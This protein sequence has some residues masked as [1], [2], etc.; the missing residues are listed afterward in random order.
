MC[1]LCISVKLWIVNYT[2][3]TIFRNKYMYTHPFNNAKCNR[4]N[5]P[6]HRIN[7][8]LLQ[9]V[10]LSMISLN[11]WHRSCRR[12]IVLS[13]AVI[14]S[15]RIRPDDVPNWVEKVCCSWDRVLVVA[16]KVPDTVH[17]LCR[18]DTN[19]PGHWSKT[20]SRYF[21]KLCAFLSPAEAIMYMLSYHSPLPYTVNCRQIRQRTV[22]RMGGRRRCRSFR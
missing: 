16:K 7:F 3:V 13:M 11:N 12:A 19:K 20:F 2:T 22:L 6:T 14:P 9:P 18:A 8:S 21:H 1:C 10:R 15:I 17:H 5:W 4:A